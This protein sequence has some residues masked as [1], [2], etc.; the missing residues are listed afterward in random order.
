MGRAN[1][2]HHKFRMKDKAERIEKGRQSSYYT[3][4]D[5]ERLQKWAEAARTQG[6]HLKS[7]SCDHCRNPRRSRIYR[8][9]ES[10]TLQE[11]R[12][13]E[14]Y[15]S[16]IEELELGRDSYCEKCGSIVGLGA[17]VCGQCGWSEDEYYIWWDD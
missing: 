5:K 13:Q 9:H 8:G 12:F 2:R 10:L 3:N 15:Q 7:C 17:D 11:R 1:R 14:D 16:Q 4:E 6:D